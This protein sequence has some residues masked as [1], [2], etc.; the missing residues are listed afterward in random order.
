MQQNLETILTKLVSI[1]SV[2]AN[3]S[4]CHE[5][6]AYV[7]SEMANLGL[8]IYSVTD[9]PNP[10]LIAT[11]QDTKTP[12]ILLAAHLDVV[13][14]PDHMFAV[15]R[16][17]DNLH[18]RG[19]YDMKFA[20][21]CYIELLKAHADKLSD[22]NIGILFTTDE[23]GNSDSMQSI[24]AWGL[25][26]KVVFLP[27]GGDNWS[28]EQ[29]AKGLYSVE[30]I[31]HGKNAHGSRP[32]EGDNALHTIL[33]IVH[34]LRQR[35]P[36][37]DPVD[38]TLSATVIHS[39]QAVN[40]IPHV[41]SVKIDFRCFDIQELTDY[42]RLVARLA[43][44]YDL[45]LHMVNQG[46]PVHFDPDHPAVQTFKKALEEQTGRDIA[47]RDSYGAT[48]ARY[49]AGHNIPCII[50]EPHGGGRHSDDEWI[51]ATDLEQYYQLIERWVLAKV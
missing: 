47:Y 18:G 12:D 3:S 7:Q 42:R 34:T 31:A 8:T 22:L 4:A 11:T 16:R 37:T 19:V 32:W 1:P 49:F 26:P 23:E 21:S 51:K 43:G 27:D 35:Y 48:D 46:D 29:R 50:I 45:D 40:Q 9:T 20:A 24:M 2:T 25:H 33:D 6:L 28:I 36:S 17:G 10:W 41:A 39:G 5:I 44:E 15:E 14:A 30:L 13:P 38:P